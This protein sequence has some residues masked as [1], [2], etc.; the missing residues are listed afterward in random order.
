MNTIKTSKISFVDAKLADLSA[1]SHLKNY[2]E[3]KL[4]EKDLPIWR[5][6]A[7]GI[8]GAFMGDYLLAEN[9]RQTL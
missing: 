5:T 2:A 8:E 9:L 4:Y 1:A 7:S 6:P 3:L